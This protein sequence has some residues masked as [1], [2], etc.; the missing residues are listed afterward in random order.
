M[1]SVSWLTEDFRLKGNNLDI[2]YQPI[3]IKD[4]SELPTQSTHTYFKL[5]KTHTCTHTHKDQNESCV[6]VHTEA[7]ILFL[8][9]FITRHFSFLFCDFS[10]AV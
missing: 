9:P 8:L 7:F 4:I 1:I 10:K 2:K 6:R 3:R 5:T